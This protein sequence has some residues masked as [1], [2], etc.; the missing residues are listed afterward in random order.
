A[1]A[2]ARRTLACHHP[3]LRR[4]CPG[5]KD[6]LNQR[7]S[8]FFTED[9]LLW[10]PRLLRNESPGLEASTATAPRV[11]PSSAAMRAPGSFPA[12]AFSLAISSAFHVRLDSGIRNTPV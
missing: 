11:R 5:S 4:N 8:A 2:V 7:S 12:M 1:P 10:P 3:G 6:R 9:S